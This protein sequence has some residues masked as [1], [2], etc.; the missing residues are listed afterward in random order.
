MGQELTA[1]TKYR[2]LVK[3][4][5]V[6]VSVSGPMPDAGAAITLDGRDVGEMKSGLDG[7]G[8][9]L[10]RLE[11]ID[12]GRPLTAGET[13]LTVTPPAWLRRPE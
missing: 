2:G 13:L 11:A 12:A 3:K 10:L 7:V 8:L 9:A 6:P 5:L 4:R 1:R